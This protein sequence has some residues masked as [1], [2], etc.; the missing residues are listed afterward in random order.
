M[1]DHG[2]V[3]RA[4][5][6]N[7]K[8]ARAARRFARRRVPADRHARVAVAAHAAVRRERHAAAQ[9]GARPVVVLSARG[10]LPI[11]SMVLMHSHGQDFHY[12]VLRAIPRQVSTPT[13]S[14]SRS[15]PVTKSF[16]SLQKC[17]LL[18]SQKGA[19]G[20]TD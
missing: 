9:R 10:L 6:P 7:E 14:P 11:E 4:N 1:C 5:P 3:H 13:C 18:F 19:E 20:I 15:T 8:G 16:F 2:Q 17:Y 12:R